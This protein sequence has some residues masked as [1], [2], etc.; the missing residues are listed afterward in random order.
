MNTLNIN[1]HRCFEMQYQYIILCSI[2]SNT[3]GSAASNDKTYPALYHHFTSG[4]SYVLLN[5]EFQI[6]RFHHRNKRRLNGLIGGSYQRVPPIGLT[7]TWLLSP[8][9]SHVGRPHNIPS[10]ASHSYQPPKLS[11]ISAISGRLSSSNQSLIDPARVASSASP[12]PHHSHYR[13]K[14]S[15]T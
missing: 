13:Q 9:T 5:S 4:Q 12:S 15:V 8:L 6:W 10:H 1:P 11:V 7:A 14:A 3:S 2:S